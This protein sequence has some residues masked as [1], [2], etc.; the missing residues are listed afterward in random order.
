V[1][2]ARYR[3]QYLAK[4]PFGYRRHA[5]TGVRIP[6]TGSRRMAERDLIVERPN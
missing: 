3:E 5:S 2:F 4:D 1:S 6:E